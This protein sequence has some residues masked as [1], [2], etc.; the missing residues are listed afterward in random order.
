MTR[1]RGNHP[2]CESQ[3]MGPHH[4]KSDP[5]FAQHNVVRILGGCLD[6]IIES[7]GGG[8]PEPDSGVG[9]LSHPRATRPS[10]HPRGQH[11]LFHFYIDFTRFQL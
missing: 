8:A 6:D 5:I 9:E 11:R 2:V 7:M 10:S 4:P 3:A 1:G